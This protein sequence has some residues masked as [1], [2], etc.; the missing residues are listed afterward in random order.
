MKAGRDASLMLHS[1]VYSGNP[2]SVL[3]VEPSL[4]MSRLGQR[5]GEARA[6]LQSK[7]KP[8]RG[9]PGQA[10]ADIRWASSVPGSRP[11]RLNKRQAQR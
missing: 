11:T 8:R 9:L 1:Q 10:K 4:E 7:Q 3:A 6:K 2:S 5:I